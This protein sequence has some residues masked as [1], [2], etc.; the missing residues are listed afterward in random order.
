MHLLAKS[1]DSLVKAIA[2]GWLN[3]IAGVAFGA[4]KAVVIIAALIYVLE[5][6]INAKFNLIPPELINDS[7][8]YSPIR[9]LIEWI[10]PKLKDLKVDEIN[11]Q[12]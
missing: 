1:L 9:E 2:L 8:L 5:H 12:K 4:A 3:K 6:F 7:L 10:Y 11:I